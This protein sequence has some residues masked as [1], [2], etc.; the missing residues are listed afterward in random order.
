MYFYGQK[1]YCVTRKTYLYILKKIYWVT[2]YYSV[3]ISQQYSNNNLR[4]KKPCVSP[5]D[6][7]APGREMVCLVMIYIKRKMFE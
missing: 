2:C 5:D 7:I 1:Q 4:K 3:K 6:Y